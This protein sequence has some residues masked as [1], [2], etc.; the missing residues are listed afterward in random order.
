MRWASL[1]MLQELASAAAA[2]QT[3]RAG[4]AAASGKGAAMAASVA[5]MAAVP[6]TVTDGA[7]CALDAAMA[8]LRAQH[9]AVA[10][11]WTLVTTACGTRGGGAAGLAR[12]GAADGGRLLSVLGVVGRAVEAEVR[13]ALGDSMMAQLVAFALP[14]PLVQSVLRCLGALTAAGTATGAAGQAATGQA[15][16]WTATLVEQCEAGLRKYLEEG[17]PGA[18]ASAP[19]VEAAARRLHTLGEVALVGF[20]AAAPEEKKAAA[21]SS[22]SLPKIPASAVRV[23]RLLLA[24][25]LPARAD[26]GAVTLTAAAAAAREGPA[27]PPAVRAHAFSTLGKLCLRD[28]ALAK[29]HVT[30][31]VRGLSEAKSPAVRSN[32]LLVLGDLC[33]RYTSLV[34]RYVPEMARRL[35]DGNATVRRHALSLLTRLLLQ[36]FIKWGDMGGS[37]AAANGGD[38]SKPRK[39]A[40]A[41]LHEGGDEGSSA[42]ATASSLFFGFVAALGDSEPG[43]R[44]LSAHLLAGPLLRRYP[45]LYHKNFVH[46]FYALNG[47]KVVNGSV[48]TTASATADGSG[49]S[50]ELAPDMAS[51]PER[52]RAVY[53]H[54]LERL[55][56]QQ[57]IEAVVRL[58]V[59]VLPTLARA[60]GF[61]GA[62][63]SAGH[64]I[65]LGDAAVNTAGGGRAAAAF[66]DALFVLSLPAMQ[67]KG[68]G[69]A[70]G[71]AASAASLAEAEE[72]LADAA[73]D[74]A[75]AAAGSSNA[76]VQALVFAGAQR[77]LLATLWRKKLGDDV[78]PTLL[79]LKAQLV[80]L[81]SPLLAALERHVLALYR[82]YR[83]EVRAA[84][85]A[86]PTG[87]REL[88]FDLRR[89]EAAEKERAAQALRKKA[90]QQ[91]HALAMAERA[92]AAGAAGSPSG[93]LGAGAAGVATAIFGTPGRKAR[94]SSSTPA[95]VA[96]LSSFKSA[97]KK[98]PSLRGFTPAGAMG[99][100]SQAQRRQS[101]VGPGSPLG[102]A[103]FS[104]PRL[105]Q[106]PMSGAATTPSMA[107][108]SALRAK[109]TAAGGQP[110]FDTTSH[111]SLA[112][113]AAVRAAAQSSSSSS[114]AAALPK[115]AKGTNADV[116]LASPHV[117]KAQK[118]WNVSVA[119]EHIAA[120]SDSDGGGGGG[121]DDDGHAEEGAGGE[122]TQRQ[123]Q[124]AAPLDSLQA[125]AAAAAPATKRASSKRKAAASTPK[126]K[127]AAAEPTDD[128]GA[129]KK[130]RATRRSTRSTPVRT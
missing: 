120:E 56:D 12:L 44:A 86:D 117:Q 64:S 97:H 106:T 60:R 41:L 39:A 111:A 80:A 116:L 11:M 63:V 42:D 48:Q 55:D 29:E 130:T 18:V 43:L 22:A 87:L 88:E 77:K 103:P 33:V 61:N 118:A 125:A 95:G 110:D 36:N 71:A 99:S 57:R 1:A 10:Q 45:S 112:R 15:A 23:V 90:R 24:E 14:A 53:A 38:E 72:D 9:A 114:P 31:L 107:V 30:V 2:A 7:G 66:G 121:D 4:D 21:S 104:A 128:G 58:V 102:A 85:A 129:Q 126:A 113:V 40:T 75:Q 73:A 98:T 6:A 93:G 70:A 27:T 54:M 101:G 122:N 25:H 123:Q 67:P 47:L 8:Q 51:D 119:A 81:K 32:I 78:V 109:S 76:A 65:A 100:N 124:A 17:P 35:R 127:T 108:A 84:L 52:R 5:A 94:S 28:Q 82:R 19:A 49:S 69:A 62:A 105:R 26:A 68:S 20:E 59:D 79:A 3:K 13:E 74:G 34:D 92:K 91:A 89:V 50:Q 46:C 37:S 96:S 115:R 16:S 83:D